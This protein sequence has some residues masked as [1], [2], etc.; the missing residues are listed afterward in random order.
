MS[1]DPPPSPPAPPALVS[2]PEPREP[3][4]TFGLNPPRWFLVGTAKLVVMVTVTFSLYQIYW[5]YKQW[6]RV[7]DAGDDVAPAPRALFSIVFCHSLFR[8]IIDSTHAAGVRTGLPAW[9]LAVGFILPS[10]AWRV[11]GGW[12]FLGFLSVVPLAAAQRIAT[13][14][15]IAQGSTED[16]N[17]RL[18]LLNWGGAVAGAGLMAVM[19]L[20]LA[21]EHGSLGP[22]PTSKEYLSG[23]AEAVNRT[24]PRRLDDETELVE[25]IGLD[26]VLVYRYRLVKRSF[27]EM[28]PARLY[29]GLRPGLVSQA[30]TS[31]TRE[32]ILDR[33]V[34]V[35]HSYGDKD[36]RE[37]VAIEILAADCPSPAR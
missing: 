5:F 24:L 2:A 36:G 28:D 23:V 29:Q 32:T 31:S 16:R 19:L 20:G 11:K 10:L 1:V 13:A 8:R 37:I 33:G 30:C 34:T 35:R 22:P 17:T 7:R 9:L 25:T 3:L 6:D 4:L 21:L 26:R 12:A 15:A 18:S 27:D 14:V